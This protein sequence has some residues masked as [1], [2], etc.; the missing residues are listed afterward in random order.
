MKGVGRSSVPTSMRC[1]IKEFTTMR[2]H[3]SARGRVAAC[4]SSGRGRG[5]SMYGCTLERGHTNARW[6]GVG[7][8]SGLYRILAGIDGKQVTM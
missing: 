5:Q 3:S 8:H 4:H 1:F 6:R 2:G 7:S